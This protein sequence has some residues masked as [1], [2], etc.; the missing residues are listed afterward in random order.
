MLVIYYIIN[1]HEYG[2]FTA[3]IDGVVQVV[4]VNSSYPAI[5]LTQ[6][7][8]KICLLISELKNWIC[9]LET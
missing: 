8:E 2:V 3:A 5:K 4:G 7:V 6:Y 9:K 1:F